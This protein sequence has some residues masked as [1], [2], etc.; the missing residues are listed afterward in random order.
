M[1]RRHP[2]RV[3]SQRTGLSSHVIR[4]WERRYGAVEPD[5][6]GTNRRLYSDSEIDRLN[7]LRQITQQGHNIGSVARMPSDELKRMMAES[8]PQP[9]NAEYLEEALA[10]IEQFDAAR[11]EEVL[12]RA[13][14][15][16][17]AQGLLLKVIGPLIERIGTKWVDGNLRIAHEHFASAVL[18]SFLS[19]AGK[20]YASLEGAPALVVAT[21]PG[22]LHELGAVMVAAAAGHL[23]W[24]VIYLGACL[25]AAEIAC[26]AI[27]NRAL[28]VALS[29]VYP[30]D[31]ANL[32]AELTLLRRLLPSE[33]AIL[34]GGRAALTY[35]EALIGIG[36]TRLSGLQDLGAALR[37]LQRGVL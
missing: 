35:G 6:S 1:Q 22:Q 10:A 30:E 18:R 36:A 2:I 28:G 33:I 9:G 15:A 23:G 25:P 7:L 13:T 37:A 4:V 3:V 29:L 27:Q 32:P 19:R 21:P 8:A 26:V 14:V 20:P 24:R 12:N 11:L 5:R 31:D 17:G 16:F 34:A